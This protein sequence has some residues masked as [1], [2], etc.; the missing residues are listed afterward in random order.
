MVPVVESF[1]AFYRRIYRPMVGLAVVLSGH[2][3]IAEEVAQDALLAALQSWNR[4]AQMDDPAA[5]V[6]RVVANRSVSIFR[7]SVTEM[8]TLARLGA[9]AERVAA[10][11]DLVAALDLW[12]TV[13]RVLPRRQAVAV[14]LRYA[15]GLTLAEIA[16]VMECSMSTANTHLRRGHQRLAEE[17][18][19][20]WEEDW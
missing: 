16:E 12:R 11:D 8:K 6:R 18:G 5:W 14:A 2:R 9:H 7:R 10:D 1:E 3:E 20:A 19:S 17:L 4:V 15:E 13:R